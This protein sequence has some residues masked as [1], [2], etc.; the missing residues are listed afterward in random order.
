MHTSHTALANVDLTNR[1]NLTCP[2][3]FANAN[4]AGYLFEP[5]LDQVRVMLETLRNER[6]VDGRVVQF[7]GGEPTIYPQ[8]FEILYMARDMGVHARPSGDERYRARRPGVREDAKASGLNTPYLQFDVV[9]DNVYL[10]TRGKALL[11]TKMKVIENCRA[12]GMKV[13]FVPTNREGPR[14][15][16]DW[17]YRARRRREHRH[18]LRHQF[19]ARCVHRPHRQTRTPG[20]TLHPC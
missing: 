11:E 10:R 19:P 2:V 16:S 15:S 1:C 3:C 9:T 6:P 7:S 20:Q 4:V 13:V 12:T 8:F 14:R 18:S 17:R 5:C